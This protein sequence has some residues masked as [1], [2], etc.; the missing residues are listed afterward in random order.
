[1]AVSF[2]SATADSTPPTVSLTLP[3][4]GATVSGTT[5]L[6]AD[7]SDKVAVDPVSFRVDGSAVNT[8][9]TAPCS[10]NSDPSLVANGSHSIL[11][12]AVDTRR[13]RHAE[14]CG[15]GDRQQP[16]LWRQQRRHPKR[17]QWDSHQALTSAS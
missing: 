9:S 11:A 13:Q 7:A 3:W 6:S 14:L 10:Y 8:D 15:D 1:M 4:D 2:G 5:S 12:L 17:R 16:G